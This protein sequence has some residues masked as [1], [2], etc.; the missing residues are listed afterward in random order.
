MKSEKRDDTQ[1]QRCY[2]YSPVSCEIAFIILRRGR[3]FSC[4]LR[5]GC[6]GYSLFINK[7]KRSKEVRVQTCD[8]LETPEVG[9][10]T[11]GKLRSVLLRWPPNT[12]FCLSLKSEGQITKLLTS[13]L[14]EKSEKCIK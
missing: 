7:I 2:T 10:S 12:R 1:R 3:D 5:K 9:G 13:R 11:L 6:A 4:F 14:K 8:W